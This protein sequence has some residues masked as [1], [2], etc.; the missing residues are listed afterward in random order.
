MFLLGIHALIELP[1]RGPV[2][3]TA[4]SQAFVTLIDLLGKNLLDVLD[5]MQQHL[6]RLLVRASLVVDIIDFAQVI[7]FV[8]EQLFHSLVC[9]LQAAVLPKVV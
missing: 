7:A 4:L 8:S 6:F 3:I 5:V 2:Q 1:L 9:V